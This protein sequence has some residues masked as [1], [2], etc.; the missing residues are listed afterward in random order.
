MMN[1]PHRVNRISFRREDFRVSLDRPFIPVMIGALLLTEI[2]VIL[3]GN[4]SL[5]TALLV[6][7]IAVLALCATLLTLMSL[8][9]HLEVGPD[10]IDCYDLW[11]RPR[12]TNWN[13]VTNT[14]FYR[15]FGL[16]YMVIQV[17]GR[18]RPMWIPLFVQ[19]YD[20]FREMV[21]T[22]A[23]NDQVLEQKLDQVA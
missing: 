6:I 5:H 15:F 10:G 23:H 22:Y 13:A 21:L 18:R 12:H 17:P 9:Y 8:R 11:V 2:L 4:G 1:L 16:N 7:P 14:R 19:R 20:L 3:P